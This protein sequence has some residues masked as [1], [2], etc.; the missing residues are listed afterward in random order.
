M[1]LAVLESDKMLEFAIETM[2][3]QVDEDEENVS[4]KAGSQYISELSH[5]FFVWYIDNPLGD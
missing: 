4:Q 1:F 3:T 5:V 2:P